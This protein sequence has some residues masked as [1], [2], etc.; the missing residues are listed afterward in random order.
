VGELR[1]HEA[2]NLY[3]TD[4][5]AAQPPIRGMSLQV[6][7]GVGHGGVAA[8]RLV[9]DQPLGGPDQASSLRPQQERGCR[10]QPIQ[11]VCDEVRDP[12]NG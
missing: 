10:S 3:L 5:V 11:A 8:A 7:Q 12:D 6:F 9:K 2:L 1:R 4:P